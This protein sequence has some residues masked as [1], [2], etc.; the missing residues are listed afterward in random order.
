MSD[1]I[2]RQAAIDALY[3]VDENNG[4]SI[5]AI[6]GLPS[7]QPEVLAHG[8]GELSA[9]PEQTDCEYCHEDSGGYVKPLEKNCHAYIRFGVHGWVIELK[10]KGWSGKAPINFCPIC[11]RRLNH[12]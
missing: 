5:E 12:G 7:V 8:E 2:D 1:L 3:H 6:R 9:E 4:W 11:G 10:A